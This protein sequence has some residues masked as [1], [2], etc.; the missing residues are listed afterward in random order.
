MF[1]INLEGKEVAKSVIDLF[2]PLTEFAGAI[3][4]HIRIYRKLSVLQ[5]LHR[6][7]QKADKKNI[8]LEAPPLKFLI[9]YLE[10]VSLEDGKSEILN[11]LWANLLI[12]SATKY[13][14]EYNLFIRILGELSPKEAKFFQYIAQFHKQ[15]PSYGHLHPVDIES[16]FDNTYFYIAFRDLLEKHKDTDLKKLDFSS[17]YSELREE[18]ESEGS[19]LHFFWVFAGNK[20]QYPYDSLFDSPRTEY[21][22]LWEYV[23]FSMLKGFGLIGEF[24]SPEYWFGKIGFEIRTVFLTPLGYSF[25]KACIKDDG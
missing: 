16:N 18:H 24:N 12:S 19:I 3:G 22:D 21:S 17:F 13:E 9:P 14:S 20:N 1:S 23:T 10:Q 25:Y 15:N 6:V 5:T 11:E 7:K 2:S 4:D 8:H